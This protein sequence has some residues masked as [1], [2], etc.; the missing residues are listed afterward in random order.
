MTLNIPMALDFANNSKRK[1]DDTFLK[2]IEDT[3]NSS[4]KHGYRW[5]YFERFPIHRISELE[6]LVIPYGYKVIKLAAWN[7]FD[8]QLIVIP[9]TEA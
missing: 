2:D 7:E 1:Q 4:Y 5:A 3:I 6:K 8:T 9:V